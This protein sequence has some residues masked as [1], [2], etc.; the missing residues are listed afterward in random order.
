MLCLQDA[1]RQ[2]F[3]LS[4]FNE[5]LKKIIIA[6]IFIC[7]FQNGF[8]QTSDSLANLLKTNLKWVTSKV[9]KK[10][11]GHRY[12]A[13]DSIGFSKDLK[14]W[15]GVG[16]TLYRYRVRET[17]QRPFKYAEVYLADANNERIAR[18]VISACWLAKH[19]LTEA[20]V[21]HTLINI[22]TMSNGQF[23][24]MGI[25][26]EDMDGKGLKPWLFVDG[27]TVFPKIP[28]SMGVFSMKR[29]SIRVS[30]CRWDV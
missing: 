19:Q 8:A 25:V 3:K 11:D 21:D 18:W 22:D 17:K 20:L 30:I 23:P 5:K 27:V 2:A 15:E 12:M 6:A 4:Q 1:C 16:V 10:L 28:L 9:Q 26:Y 24:V 29:L 14:G 7:C 13:M